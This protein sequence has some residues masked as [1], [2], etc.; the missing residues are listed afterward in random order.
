MAVD[1]FVQNVHRF[2][3]HS[4]RA[5]PDQDIGVSIFQEFQLRDQV[6]ERDDNEFLC[7][8]VGCM[9]SESPYIS[10]SSIHGPTSRK[11]EAVQFWISCES[12]LNEL[13]RL[14]YIIVAGSRRTLNF[15]LTIS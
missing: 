11:K 14:R 3:T 15:L 2:R 8:Y 13:G 10:F 9:A 4:S 1:E 5:L 6:V 12:V 7:L